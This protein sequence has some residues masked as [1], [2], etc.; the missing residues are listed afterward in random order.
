MTLQ[1]QHLKRRFALGLM[2]SGLILVSSPTRASEAED[3]QA[4]QA[5]L[6]T[7]MSVRKAADV[8][9]IFNLFHEDATIWAQNLTPLEGKAAIHAFM[10]KAL[11][12][13]P[14]DVSVE[15]DTLEIDGDLAFLSALTTM[16]VPGSEETEPRTLRY[17]DLVV[18]QK[19]DGRW[20]VLQD[21][22]QPVGGQAHY[23]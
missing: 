10:S 12:V 7:Y 1:R 18:L 6:D 20:R 17:R 8:D 5:L 22:D 13:K 14:S 4:I 11:T 9:G 23:E 21:I 2:L 3:R 19:R 15:I 16:V